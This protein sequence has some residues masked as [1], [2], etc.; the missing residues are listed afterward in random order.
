MRRISILLLLAGF[1]WVLP[2]LPSVAQT[3]SGVVVDLK[4]ATLRWYIDK[5]IHIRPDQAK[6]VLFEA[7]H[8]GNTQV[9]ESVLESLNLMYRRIRVGANLLQILNAHDTRG[10]TPLGYAAIHGNTGMATALIKYGADP[11]GTDNYGNTPVMQA[12]L[13]DDP[14]MVQLLVNHGALVNYQSATKLEQFKT[15]K[16]SALMAAVQGNSLE[17]AKMLIRLGADLDERDD[18]N[19]TALMHAAA[20]GNSTMAG[21]LT[22]SGA[23]LESRDHL[24]RTALI[25]AII[26][27]QPK[28]V[29]LLLEAGAD[30]SAQDIQRQGPLE[31]ATATGDT[32]SQVL[33]R[34]AIARSQW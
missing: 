13:H 31:Y 11:N 22:E 16:G 28:T 29:R 4:P 25:F 17:T 30:V 6:A 7:V 2:P 10:L 18:S 1:C 20:G 19:M 34:R 14:E 23:N 12:A 33:V 3:V 27:L 24:G 8:G 15:L 9:V 5:G 26:R 32:Q 21:L